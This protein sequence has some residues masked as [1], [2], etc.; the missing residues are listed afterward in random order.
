M[1]N[2]NFPFEFE[3]LA[4]AAIQV[5]DMNKSL[6]FYK[7]L[8]GLEVVDSDEKIAFLRC[9]NDHH[10]LVLYKGENAGI[11]RV[12]FKLKTPN[13]LVKAY[14]YFDQEGLE[15]SWVEKDETW[16]LKQGDTFRIREPSSGLV[17]EFFNDITYMSTPYKTHN[18]KIARIGHVVIGVKKYEEVVKNLTTK[19]NFAIS[20]FV[21]DKFSWMRCRPNPLHHSFAVGSSTSNHLH[22]INFMVTDIDDIGAAAARMKDA[23]VKIVFG[24]GRHLPSTSI[25][26]YFLD[27]DGLTMEFSFGMEEIYED[28]ARMPRML[29]MHPKTMDM[30]GG[31][32]P[33]ELFGKIGIIEGSY[34]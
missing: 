14:G 19:M 26:L 18:T 10:N 23:G 4:Y 22:H 13:D 25:F 8:M 6:N 31:P 15:P 34:E 29:E 27:P 30:W 33:H 5:T 16:L 12:A 32:M 20:D 7:E 17:F 9:S 28:N 21:D 11:K 2:Q 24:P 3:K 1:E